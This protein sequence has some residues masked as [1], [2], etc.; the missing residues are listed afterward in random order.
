VPG[1]PSLEEIARN[2]FA[3]HGLPTPVEGAWDYY[4]G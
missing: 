2:A 4:A 1:C 3:G